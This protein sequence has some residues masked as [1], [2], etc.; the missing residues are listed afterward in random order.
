MIPLLPLG[1]RIEFSANSPAI[2]I[3]KQHDAGRDLWT[4]M[5]GYSPAE[6]RSLALGLLVAAEQ[7]DARARL[8]APAPA[9]KEGAPCRCDSTFPAPEDGPFHWL[10]TCPYLSAADREKVA[11]AYRQPAPKEA[12]P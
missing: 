5:H 2:T 8:A 4:F 1:W 7:I 6:A 9:P 3:C 11:K 12:K 10:A